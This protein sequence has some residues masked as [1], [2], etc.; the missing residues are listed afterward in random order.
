MLK[1]EV[2]KYIEAQGDASIQLFKEEKEYAERNHLLKEG[3]SVVEKQPSERFTDAYIERGD[4]ETE[5]FLGEESSDFLNQPIRYFKEHKNE[6]MYLETKWFDIIGVD[7]VSFEMDDVFGTYDVML[8]LKLQK[9]Y[10]NAINRYLESELKGE[11]AKFNLMFDA[12]E[13]I[14]NMNFAL[15]G[16]EGFSENL[17]INEACNIIYAFLFK[18][19][20]RIEQ[21]E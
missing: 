6:F 12:N 17:T 7:A 20:E 15:N 13:G 4:K 2:Q 1:Q 5:N 3:V 18:L 19:A 11:A 9:K 16:N 8:G 14:W 10:G 21:G